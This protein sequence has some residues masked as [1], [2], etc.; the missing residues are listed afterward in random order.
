MSAT[1]KLNQPQHVG[2]SNVIEQIGAFLRGAGDRLLYVFIKLGENSHAAHKAREFQALSSLSD[3]QLAER[4]LTRDGLAIH[5][6]GP[7]YS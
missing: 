5:V 2:T 3:E 7:F 4:G 1:V 6:F